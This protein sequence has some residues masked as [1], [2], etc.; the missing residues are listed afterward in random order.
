M[1]AAA[2]DPD[3]VVRLR[4]WRGLHLAHGGDLFEA[5]ADEIERL[6][7]G[8]LGGCETVQPATTL[9]AAPAATA[10]EA[11][12]S[13]DQSQRGTGD[14]LN[15]AM[16]MAGSGPTVPANGRASGCSEDGR[17]RA[18]A[19]SIGNTQ[20]PAAWAI[21]RS[22]DGSLMGFC[23]TKRDATSFA[24]AIIDATRSE[25]FVLRHVPLY[26]SPTLTPEEREAIKVAERDYADN[27]MDAGCY[28][29]AATLRSLLERTK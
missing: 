23:H 18:S 2:Y 13:P 15:D 24:H 27:D 1:T 17:V 6:R 29:I 7:N 5:A 19:S 9:D 28:H 26:R 25:R 14:T 4:N 20:K 11:E 10:S 3:I 8:T 12:R 21:E 22:E 16:P